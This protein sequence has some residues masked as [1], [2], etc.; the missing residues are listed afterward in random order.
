MQP[1]VPITSTGVPGADD[2]NTPDWLQQAAVAKP[3]P[4]KLRAAAAA[5]PVCQQRS[6]G[7]QKVAVTSTLSWM[8]SMK[9][10]SSMDL[11][12]GDVQAAIAQAKAKA[13]PGGWLQMGALGAPDAVDEENE[14]EEARA[15]SSLAR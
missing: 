7:G 12:D 2:T 11:E 9:R 1:T 3:K 13:V 5:C 8:S 14:L 10:R 15:A 4:T 6:N